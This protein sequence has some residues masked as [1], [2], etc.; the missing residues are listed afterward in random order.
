MKG[1]H[2]KVEIVYD[3]SRQYN[4]ERDYG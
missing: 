2:K 1:K 3:S 4:V